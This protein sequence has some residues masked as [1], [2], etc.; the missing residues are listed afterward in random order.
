MPGMDMAMEPIDYRRFIGLLTELVNEGRVPISRIDDAVTRILRVK[1]AMALMDKKRSPLA[2]RR[3]HRSL[4]LLN[5]VESRVNV[6]GNRW[7]F[8]RTR[9]RFCRCQRS[10]RG[11]MLAVKS[12][13]DIGNQCGGW[14]IDWQ[15][16]SGNITSGGTTI[17]KAIQQAV[18][19]A[20]KV[21]F[22]S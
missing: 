18:S 19:P 14:T 3:L 21:T 13:D 17:L 9:K 4:A 10:S 6:C 12:A 7:Y 11:F 8:S 22:S 16:K 2:D 5:T 1:F 20:T 15:G